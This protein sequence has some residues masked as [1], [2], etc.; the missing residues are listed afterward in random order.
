MCFF[1]FL[2]NVFVQLVEILI[3]FLYN[4]YFSIHPERINEHDSGESLTIQRWTSRIAKMAQP[5]LDFI[6]IVLY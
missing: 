6:G 4:C 5:D 1:F 3:H 2:Y